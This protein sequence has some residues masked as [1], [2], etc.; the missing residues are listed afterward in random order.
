ME[1][2]VNQTLPLLSTPIRRVPE[3]CEGV[4]YWVHFSVVGLN[5]N[6]MCLGRP[7][8]QMLSCGSTASPYGLAPGTGVGHSETFRVLASSFPTA[9]PATNQYQTLSLESTTTCSIAP[10]V[11]TSCRMIRPVPGSNSPSLPP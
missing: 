9:L 6:T 11:G 2:S 7:T 8:V 10:S 5:R 4:G 3:G 1:Y